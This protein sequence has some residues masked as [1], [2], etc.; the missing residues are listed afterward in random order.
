MNNHRAHRSMGAP[1]YQ[2]ALAGFLPVLDPTAIMQL[3]L[4]A[5]VLGL[6]LAAV[7][8]GRER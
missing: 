6:V 7:L 2:M 4:W 1:S 8:E 3:V 5:A